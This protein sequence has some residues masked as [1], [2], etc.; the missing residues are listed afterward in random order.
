[1]I[2]ETGGCPANRSYCGRDGVCLAFCLLISNVVHFRLYLGW[3]LP[4]PVTEWLMAIFFLRM[5]WLQDVFL[6]I[7]WAL[8][9]LRSQSYCREPSSSLSFGP[10]A[11]ALWNDMFHHGNQGENWFP[12]KKMFDCRK[13]VADESEIIVTWSFNPSTEPQMMCDPGHPIFAARP[14]LQPCPLPLR[15]RL[16]WL[17]IL[18]RWERRWWRRIMSE[19]TIHWTANLMEAWSD[20][21]VLM[22][23]PQSFA[24]LYACQP[25]KDC[26]LAGYRPFGIWW[27][28]LA[29]HEFSWYVM[30]FHT[31]L[32]I[33]IWLATRW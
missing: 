5:W 15:C 9:I 11:E 13:H 29:G 6:W 32:G 31:C 16:I 18:K 14:G 12:N 8:P 4:M 25:A 7:R 23:E 28:I 17:E 1:M 20:T 26:R 10:W 22:H 21:I 19:M 33:W 3:C 24:T 27:G 30:I 2:A